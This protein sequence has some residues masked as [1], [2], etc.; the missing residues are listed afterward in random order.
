MKKTDYEVGYFGRI[1][2]QGLK[3]RARILGEIEGMIDNLKRINR[4]YLEVVSGLS[5]KNAQQVKESTKTRRLYNEAQTQ[6]NARLDLIN[7]DLGA[8]V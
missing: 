1:L 2:D 8:R 4:E 5:I 7:K 6:I 3:E